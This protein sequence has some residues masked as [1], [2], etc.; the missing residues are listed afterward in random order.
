MVAVALVVLPACHEVTDRGAYVCLTR[1]D[2]PVQAINLPFGDAQAFEA[3]EPILM[4]V[5]I[6]HGFETIRDFSCSIDLDIATKTITLHTSYRKGRNK[7]YSVALISNTECESV[8]VPA[9][10]YEIVYGES[11][12]ALQVPSEVPPICFAQ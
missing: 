11:M 5:S 3:D 9:G 10:D 1:V 8:S 6:V 2:E 12:D 4:N 7:G